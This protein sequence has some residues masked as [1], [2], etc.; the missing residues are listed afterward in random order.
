MWTGILYRTRQTMVY[1]GAR[2]GGQNGN[3]GQQHTEETK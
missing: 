3:P 2:P 1:K